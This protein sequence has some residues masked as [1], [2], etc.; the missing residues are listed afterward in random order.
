MRG[1]SPDIMI[2]FNENV[3]VHGPIGTGHG[4]AYSYDTHVPVIFNVPG[5]AHAVIGREVNT[6]DIAPTLSAMLG[7]KPDKK[8]NGVVLNELIPAIVD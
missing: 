5:L 4:S 8:I 7:L 6:V 1:L 3:L 2:H